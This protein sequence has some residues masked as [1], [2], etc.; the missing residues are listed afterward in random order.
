MI[1]LS[2]YSLLLWAP[3]KELIPSRNEYTKN[4]V[5]SLRIYRVTIICRSLLYLLDSLFQYTFIQLLCQ[6]LHKNALELF[7]GKPYI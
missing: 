6:S 1:F 5:K 7:Q 3:K 4:T 2:I